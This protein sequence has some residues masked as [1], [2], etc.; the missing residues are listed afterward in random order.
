MFNPPLTTLAQAATQPAQTDNNAMLVWAIILI[1]MAAILLVLEILIP[2]GGLIS[3]F[4]AIC[5]IA[6]IVLMFGVDTTMGLL[7]SAVSLIAIPF[8]LGFGLKIWP[9]T[10]VGRWLTLGEPNA[11][12]APAPTTTPDAHPQLAV[13]DTG[14]ALTDLRPVGT[15]ILAKQRR[16]C[17]AV[18]EVI[19]AGTTVR[20]VAIDG[21]QIK[22]KPVPD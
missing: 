1:G 19:Q 12:N 11:T 17:L 14:K 6:G 21:M 15:C 16:D 7:A 5:L 4:A 13:G 20:I 10:P 2:S 22:V 18:G 3:V 9:N 8:I